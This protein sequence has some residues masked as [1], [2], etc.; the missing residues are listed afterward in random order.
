MLGDCANC[1]AN[2]MCYKKGKSCVPV[3]QDA[4]LAL[5]DDEERNIMQAAAYVESDGGNLCRI[6]AA[7]ARLER[8]NG[9]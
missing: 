9:Q 8:V 7:E 6:L 5:Y 3:D 4:M 2:R 1:N